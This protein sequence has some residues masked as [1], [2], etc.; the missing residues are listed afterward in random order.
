[1]SVVENDQQIAAVN[2]V[3]DEI[4]A[5]DVDRGADLVFRELA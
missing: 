1:M 5:G 4:G 2:K 3:L